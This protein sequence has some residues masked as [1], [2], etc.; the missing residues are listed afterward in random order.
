M[1]ASVCQLAPAKLNLTLRVLGRRADGYHELDSLVAF[2]SNVTDTVTLTPSDTHNISFSGPF[3][4]ELG[5]GPSTLSTTRDHLAQ[6]AVRSQSVGD[7]QLG[8]VVVDKVIPLASGL[9]GGSADSAAFLRAVM[10][11]NP[12]WQDRLDWQ[13]IACQIGADVPVC[14]ASRAQ[15]MAG[16]GD[17]LTPV[18]QFPK[19][20]AVLINTSE[21]A[22]ADKTQRV[23]AKLNAASIERN[24]PEQSIQSKLSEFTCAEDVAAFVRETGNSLLTPAR[25]LMPSLEAPL[26]MLKTQPLCLAA[27]LSGAGPTVFG[28]FLNKSDADVAARDIQSADPSWWV[29]ASVLI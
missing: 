2:A 24:P 29:K 27:G 16:L 28:L 14:L 26:A 19:L 22:L 5:T 25:S 7:L 23:F 10:A 18:S 11:C 3:S 6:A 12:T 8:D 9:G 13:A 21:P 15:F 20:A 4:G 1:I 17:K